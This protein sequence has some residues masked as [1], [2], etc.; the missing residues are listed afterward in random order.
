MIFFLFLIENFHI[1]TWRKHCLASLWHTLPSSSSCTLE[2]LLSQVRVTWTQLVTELATKWLTGGGYARQ[3]YDSCSGWDGAD[4]RFHHMTQ[5]NKQ[6]ITYELF[7]SR[8]FHLI[9]LKCSWLQVLEMAECETTDK[10]WLLSSPLLPVCSLRAKSLSRLPLWPQHM[11]LTI[12]L[13]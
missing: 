11:V 8:I 10:R 2:S 7:S 5:N 1:F 12:D 6:F 13:F 9:F 4:V 3:R